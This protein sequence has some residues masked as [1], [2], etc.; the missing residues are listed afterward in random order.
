C[1]HSRIT[2][3]LGPT[4]PE[5][6]TPELLGKLAELSD[7]EKLPVYTHLY[8]SRAMT[9]IARQTHAAED[10]G[11]LISYLKRVGLLTPRMNLAHGV[12]L[13]PAEI[14]SIPGAAAHVV[15]HPFGNLHTRTRV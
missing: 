7:T 5:R 4:S 2:L 9:L 8:E 6:C 11:S 12:W 3:A 1:R 13:L 10:G 14:D 15:V